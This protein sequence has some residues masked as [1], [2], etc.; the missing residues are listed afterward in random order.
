MCLLCLFVCDPSFDDVSMN[1]VMD[2]A[3]NNNNNNSNAAAAAAAL[4]KK[5]NVSNTRRSKTGKAN[6]GKLDI[7]N[8][9]AQTSMQ[10]AHSQSSSSLLQSDDLEQDSEQQVRRLAS[11]LNLFIY[12]G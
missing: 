3:I 8:N 12:K 5:G 9:G 10:H 7:S 6:T 11:S 2:S 4:K 1:F